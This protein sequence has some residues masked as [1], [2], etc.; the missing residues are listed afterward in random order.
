MEFGPYTMFPQAWYDD[1]SILLPIAFD[2]FH[3]HRYAYDSYYANAHIMGLFDA[4]TFQII[5]VVGQKSPRFLDYQYIPNHDFSYFDYASDTLFVS[6]E[7]DSLIFVYNKDFEPLYTFGNAGIDMNMDYK[8]SQNIDE[9]DS[10]YD[11]S[12]ARE[13]YYAYIKYFPEQ[14]ILIR[15]YKTGSKSSAARYIF[16]NPTRVQVYRNNTLIADFAARPRSRIMGYKTPY[17]YADG[18]VDEQNERLG[19]YR[20]KLDLE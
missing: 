6:H 7:P 10:H 4:S 17:F 19:V 12:R 18:I 14:N 3:S 1:N 16:E 11:Y 2:S 9:A 13:G 20:F 15:T 5:K 8:E